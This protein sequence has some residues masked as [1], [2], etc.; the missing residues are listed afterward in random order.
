MT[1]FQAVLLG[2]VQGLTEFIPVSSSAHLVIVPALL[3][4][5]IPED[6]AFVFDVLVQLGT[7]VAVLIYFR[8]DLIGLLRPWGTGLLRRA[9]FGDPRS[10]LVWWLILATIPAG[11][12]GLLLKDV[13]AS[14]FASLAASGYFLIGTGTLL[15]L[16][17]RFGRRNRGLEGMGWLD[18]L[19][20]GLFQLI[21]IFPGLSRSGSTIAGGMFRNLECQAAAR[22]SFLLSIPIMAAAG[23]LAG[24]DLLRM[25]DMGALLP[26]LTAGFLAAAAVGFMTIH[27]LL[28]YL[29]RGSLAGFA[30]YVWVLAGA[31]LL[32]KVV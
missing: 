13:V 2:I 21:A 14:A 6:Q 26:P 17:E 11:V 29:A 10:R 20:I 30:V 23:L 19:V 25:P 4:W 5:S 22:F 24:L 8:R 3:G 18:A 27:W 12:G 16:A 7:L 32:F 28:K 31:I 1:V 9:P 15:I